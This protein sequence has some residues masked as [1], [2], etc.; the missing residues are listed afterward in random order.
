MTKTNL[1]P[2]RL[3]KGEE[4]RLKQGH[5]WVYSNEVDTDATPL[6]QF[7][8]GQ[9]VNIESGQ[10]RP[11]GSAY[12]NA[13]SLICARLYSRKAQRDL[14]SELIQRRLEQALLLRQTIYTEPFYRLCYGEGDFLPGVVIDR[15]GDYLAVQLTTAGMEQ[16]K[17]TLLDALIA[18]CK[19][20]GVYWRNDVMLR[21]LEGL[22]LYAE[23]AYGEVPDFVT[24]R[25]NG[26]EFFTSLQHGQ[27]T[28]WFYDHRDNRARLQ[29]LCKGKR[30]LDVFSY[31]G[32]WGLEAV[33]AG[34]REVHCIDSS[35]TALTELARNAKH[36][37][38][39]ERCHLHAG[40]AFDL[41]QEL[42]AAKEMFDV[43]VVDPPAFV[44]R[45]KDLAQGLAAYQR[46]NQL[47]LQ[48]LNNNGILVAA[49]CS[50]HVDAS[51]LLGAVRMAA[52]NLPLRLQIIGQ[53]HQAS[54]H[55]IHPA[56]TE[57]EYLKCFFCRVIRE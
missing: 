15:F 46:I 19:P 6:R 1:P 49:S 10:G 47:A 2:L 32:A 17:A 3:R 48:L 12:V 22:P 8:A 24:V 5:L 25:E 50:Q 55:P 21:E 56:M 40:D 16:H 51:A 35:Q 30:V 36:N 14:D 41:L 11:L 31:L 28:G 38:V 52:K 42:I 29:S 34:A 53:G 54:D 43:V 57:T 39:S 45:K 9:C 23:V 18:L 20:R 7:S 33:L 44:K 26:V 37:G 27:K 4:R 13:N